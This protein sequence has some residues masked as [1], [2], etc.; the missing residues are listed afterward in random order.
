MEEVKTTEPKEIEKTKKQIK[1]EELQAL[2]DE[3]YEG[4]A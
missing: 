3:L 2:I 4:M 1:E